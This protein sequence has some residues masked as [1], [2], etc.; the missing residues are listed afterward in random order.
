MACTVADHGCVQ[1]NGQTAWLRCTIRFGR[2]SSLSLDFDVCRYTGGLYKRPPTLG[3]APRAW[4][5]NGIGE[6]A[7]SG[8][9]ASSSHLFGVS[10]LPADRRCVTSLHPMRT[11]CQ[12]CCHL[13]PHGSQGQMRVH[14]RH[15]TSV[16]V[17]VSLGCQE[18][19]SIF[20]SPNGSIESLV[21][22]PQFVSRS[23]EFELAAPIRL[24]GSSSNVKTL[25]SGSQTTRINWHAFDSQGLS[26]ASRLRDIHRETLL[27]CR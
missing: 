21:C 22:L 11:A 12:K 17:T 3:V 2:K 16:S 6:A 4:R 25:I 20:H 27:R 1:Q 23:P 13:R 14:E 15:S 9:N 7:H 10:Q 24:K 18:P 5:A 26:G 8:L 19:V